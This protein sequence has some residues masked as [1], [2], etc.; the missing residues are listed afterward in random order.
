M[1]S[2]DSECGFSL[3]RLEARHEWVKAWTGRARA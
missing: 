3:A 2:S 1:R